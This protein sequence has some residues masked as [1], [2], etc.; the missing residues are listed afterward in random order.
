MLSVTHIAGEE[1]A[2]ARQMHVASIAL[3]FYFATNDTLTADLAR[4]PPPEIV[5]A[6]VEFNK[7]HGDWLETNEEHWLIQAN[8][9]E[10]K[11]ENL[12]L[13]TCWSLLAIAQDKCFPLEERELALSGLMS[14]LG[15]TFFFEGR[16]PPPSPHWRFFDFPFPSLPAQPLYGI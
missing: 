8:F 4:F 2:G 11:Q 16:M 9:M 13:G 14:Y 12:F 6:N 1:L 3:A 7:A 5:K 10:W 15:P